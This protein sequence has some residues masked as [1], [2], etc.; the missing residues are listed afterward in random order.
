MNMVLKI[1]TILDLQKY[2]IMYKML[3]L[4]RCF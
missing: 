1:D 4:F 2:S 3:L